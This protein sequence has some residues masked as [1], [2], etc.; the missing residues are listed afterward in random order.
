MGDGKVGGDLSNFGNEWSLVRPKA[1]E[2][3]SKFCAPTDKVVSHGDTGE[4]FRFAIPVY[5]N[6]YLS[7]WM[8]SSGSHISHCWNRSLQISKG[9]KLE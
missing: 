4:Q 5:G 7:K 2:P 9:R 1:K 3:V 8:T 6:E